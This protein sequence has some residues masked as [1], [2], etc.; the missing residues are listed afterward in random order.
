MGA[1]NDNIPPFEPERSSNL[2]H[3]MTQLCDMAVVPTANYDICSQSFVESFLIYLRKKLEG[4]DEARMAAGK[5]LGSLTQ[6]FV[7]QYTAQSIKIDTPS[8]ELITIP[9][10]PSHIS[11]PQSSPPS[12]GATVFDLHTQL[13]TAT[14]LL[15]NGH[16][17]NSSNVTSTPASSPP[18]CVIPATDTIPTPVPSATDIISIGTTPP[19]TSNV[20]QVEISDIV[21]DNFLEELIGIPLPSCKF[22]WEQCPD[23]FYTLPSFKRHMKKI[24][25]VVDS[26]VKLYRCTCG[27][28]KSKGAQKH[29]INAQWKFKCER[30]TKKFYDLT[31][32]KY[33][34]K[35][36]HEVESPLKGYQIGCTLCEMKFKI[37]SEFSKH[38]KLNQ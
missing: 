32:L 3:V 4:G 36:A 10:Y 25:E 18:L 37:R 6:P 14:D 7:F 8:P 5:I 21:E 11:S 1:R 20:A 29:H 34:L 27:S 22:K 35:K 26:S 33:H 19:L 12:S 9:S 13:P 38:K 30:C 16:G 2:K 15:Q 28:K 23:K 31:T 24:H 17:K